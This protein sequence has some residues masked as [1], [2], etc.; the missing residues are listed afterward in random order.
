MSHKKDFEELRTERH[1]DQLKW[2]TAKE[3]GLTDSEFGL[4]LT[5]EE[6]G[7]TQMRRLIKQHEEILKHEGAR[8]FDPEL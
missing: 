6:F 1:L 5:P 8:K 3:A 2:E 7:V 4:E